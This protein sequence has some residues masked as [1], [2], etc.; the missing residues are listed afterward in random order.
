MNFTKEMNEV[1]KE[2]GI[3]P[4]RI[5]DGYALNSL[6]LLSPNSILLPCMNLPLTMYEVSRNKIKSYF[7]V[8]KRTSDKKK[9][10]DL[11]NG[12]FFKD[13]STEGS[14]F[15][16]S[17]IGQAVNILKQ[18]RGNI[19]SLKNINVMTSGSIQIL[20]DSS[21][22]CYHPI[23]P[24][25]LKAQLVQSYARI[26]YSYWKC[27]GTEI[28]EH[29]PRLIEEFTDCKI[30]KS[31]INT[32]VS[33]IVSPNVVDS[34]NSNNMIESDTIIEVVAS[35]NEVVENGNNEGN[36]SMVEPNLVVIGKRTG[37]KTEP[38]MPLSQLKEKESKI[39]I[40]S[41]S[42][43]NSSTPLKESVSKV[44]VESSVI[45]SQDVSISQSSKALSFG[46]VIPEV[47][48]LQKPGK[49]IN[50]LDVIKN[51]DMLSNVIDTWIEEGHKVKLLLEAMKNSIN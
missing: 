33:D 1:M 50:N 43:V 2:Q 31:F 15:I 38:F 12:H 7:K 10:H 8:V 44:T 20:A 26:M 13:V 11:L 47:L 17:L 6:Q 9:L 16:V 28:C 32:E 49:F 51:L 46:L 5:Y 25:S 23:V 40:E 37:R 41:S 29:C 18:Q 4:K 24:Q 42:F 30:R 48:N 21:F 22:S 36:E 3:N 45:P 39:N 34:I 14:R 19:Y 27:S 35:D